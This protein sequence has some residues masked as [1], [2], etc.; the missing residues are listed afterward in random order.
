MS[1]FG[2]QLQNRIEHDDLA[3]ARVLKKLG[4]AAAGKKRGFFAELSGSLGTIRQ[5]E[6]I[7]HYLDL[8]VPETISEHDSIAEQV[9]VMLQPSGA[10]RRIVELNDTWWKNGDGPLLA[11]VKDTEEI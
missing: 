9:D 10:T 11:Q 1:L 5:I 4:D 2:E 7:C 8:P 6:Q 3:Q